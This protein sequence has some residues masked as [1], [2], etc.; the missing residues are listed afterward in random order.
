MVLYHTGTFMSIFNSHSL[1]QDTVHN[2]NIP[3]SNSLIRFLGL[4]GATS[5]GFNPKLT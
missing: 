2:V 5:T 1:V 4:R 3:T